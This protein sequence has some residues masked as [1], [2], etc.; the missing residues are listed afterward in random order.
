MKK[1]ILEFALLVAVVAPQPV[2]VSLELKGLITNDSG[3]YRRL[4]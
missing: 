3:F 2:L 4:L 1:L